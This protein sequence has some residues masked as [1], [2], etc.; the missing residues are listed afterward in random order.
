MKN[1][2]KLACVLLA[3]FSLAGTCNRKVSRMNPEEIRDIS[4]RWNDTDSRLTAAK[5]ATDVVN[6][7]WINIHQ[8]ENNGKKPVV[9]VGSIQNKSHEHIEAETFVK[10]IEKEFIQTG[11]VRLVEGGKKRE[12]LRA[13]RADQQ[14]YSSTNTMKRWGLEV[15]ADYMLQ[16]SINSIVDSYKAKK[17]TYY[18]ISLQLT[19][20]QTGEVVWMEDKE[21]KKFVKN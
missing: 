21:I 20:L 14:T 9:I 13:E 18:K 16:G 7:N 11:K 6:A 1:Y 8:S 4:G 12:A 10:D 17:V 19:S 5:I 2:L 3:L 15:G